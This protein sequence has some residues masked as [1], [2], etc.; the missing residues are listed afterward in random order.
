M[1]SHSHA[2]EES[3]SLPLE[4]GQGLMVAFKNIVGR[5]S[6]YVISE[7]GSEKAVQFQLASL[8]GHNSQNLAAML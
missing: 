7:A 3:M 5:K 6:G 8:L 1:F 2:K 4:L